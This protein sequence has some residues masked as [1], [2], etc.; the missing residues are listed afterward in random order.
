MITIEDIENRWEMNQVIPNKVKYYAFEN[1]IFYFIGQWKD[2]QVLKKGIIYFLPPLLAMYIFVPILVLSWTWE[3]SIGQMLMLFFVILFSV[4]LHSLKA[5]RELKQIQFLEWVRNYIKRKEDLVNLIDKLTKWNVDLLNKKL[6]SADMNV[7]LESVIL[8]KKN[9]FDINNSTTFLRG[10]KY[11]F[12]QY[13]QNKI[14]TF[15]Q[16]ELKWLKL[17]M[18]W[19]SWI[20]SSWIADQKNE[21]SSITTN[22][23]STHI[24]SP[25]NWAILVLAKERLEMHIADLERVKIH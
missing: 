16:E 4:M 12:P 18:K 13:L 17:Y 5:F 2:L 7:Y 14:N 15:I 3:G 10:Y 8:L 11:L 9:I 20:V 19:F 21:L 1:D 23:V 6:N 22:L 24:K 25:S